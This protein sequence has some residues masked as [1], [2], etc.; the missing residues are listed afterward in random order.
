[1]L[2]VISLSASTISIYREGPVKYVMSR[3]SS[4]N[5]DS[6]SFSCFWTHCHNCECFFTQF[7]HDRFQRF[8]PALSISRNETIREWR[9]VSCATSGSP[10]PQI[11]QE[12]PRQTTRSSFT[13][14]CFKIWRFEVTV[15]ENSICF[16]ICTYATISCS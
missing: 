12:D 6:V 3:T 13:R 2:D 7:R 15:K 4:I 5:C 1:M 10:K 8:K 14:I 16:L 11:R 9:G